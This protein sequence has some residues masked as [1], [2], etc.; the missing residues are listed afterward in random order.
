[1]TAEATAQAAA[2]THPAAAGMDHYTLGT[3]LAEG[4]TFEQL[5]HLLLGLQDGIAATGDMNGLM[6]A[7]IRCEAD[8]LSR[9]F[10]ALAKGL[11]ETKGE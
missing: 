9:D 7:V 4:S 1:M 10:T 6:Y 11:T 5:A 3:K 8:D 2:A